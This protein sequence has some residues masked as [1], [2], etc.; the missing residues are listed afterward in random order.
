M[1]FTNRY[2][3]PHFQALDAD[4]LRR[5]IQAYPLATVISQAEDYPVV[6]QVPL[7]LNESGDRLIGHFD[8]NN[9]HCDELRDGGQIYCVFNGPN[10]YMTPSIYPNTQYPGWNYVAVHVAGV[11]RPVDDAAW[12][13]RLVMTMAE[14]LEPEDSGYTLTPEQAH[15][16]QFIRMVLGFEIDIVDIKGVFKLA[17]DKGRENAELARQHLARMVQRDVGDFLG[18]LLAEDSAD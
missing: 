5:V 10:H 13:E 14:T 2:P 18:D 7:M 8:R 1:K 15:F 3:L 17:Q 11:V 16:P 9:P 4:K 12:M 6:S